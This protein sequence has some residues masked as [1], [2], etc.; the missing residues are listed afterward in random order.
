MRTGRRENTRAPESY[1]TF[2]YPADDPSSTRYLC[3]I[4]PSPQKREGENADEIVSK[5]IK[6]LHRYNEAKDAAQ[7]LI[8]KVNYLGTKA[9]PRKKICILYMHAYAL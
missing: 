9:Q 5:H 8:G 7:I 2:L 4:F 6:L 3:F 1:H